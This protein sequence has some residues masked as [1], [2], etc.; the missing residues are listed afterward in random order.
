MPDKLTPQ[1]RPFCGVF[2]AFSAALRVAV[3]SVTEA[4]N[5][6][7]A[8]SVCRKGQFNAARPNYFDGVFIPYPELLDDCFDS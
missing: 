6:R 5:R 8:I 3:R 1:K 7:Q 2:V 4:A